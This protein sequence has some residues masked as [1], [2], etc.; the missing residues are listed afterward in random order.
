MK[1]KKH[2]EDCE[3]RKQ[4]YLRVVGECSAGGH[5][6]GHQQG[7]P[8]EYVKYSH[9]RCRRVSPLGQDVSSPPP[10]HND[11]ISLPLTTVQFISWTSGLTK[12]VAGPHW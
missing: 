5:C 11:S 9:E 3:V 7:D 6:L 8:A 2:G 10:P 1:E 4:S 12:I